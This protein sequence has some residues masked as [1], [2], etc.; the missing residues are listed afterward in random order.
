MDYN[1]DQNRKLLKS[2]KSTFGLV[3]AYFQ[4]KRADMIEKKKKKKEEKL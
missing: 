1:L 4:T 2:M 3:V